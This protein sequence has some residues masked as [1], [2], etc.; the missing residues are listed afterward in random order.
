MRAGCEPTQQKQEGREGK[1]SCW[2][3]ERGAG[4]PRLQMRSSAGA[5]HE[6]RRGRAFK[7]GPTVGFRDVPD[8]CRA[9]DKC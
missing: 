8:S 4:V 2:G 3:R 9:Q 1:E 6:Q 5:V 7:A